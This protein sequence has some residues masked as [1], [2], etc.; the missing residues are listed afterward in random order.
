MKNT[1][2]CQECKQDKKVSVV[3]MDKD[4]AKYFC[5]YKCEEAAYYRKNA[6]YYKP[7]GA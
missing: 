3:R 2:I 1:T 7:L 5:S 4:G 6:E